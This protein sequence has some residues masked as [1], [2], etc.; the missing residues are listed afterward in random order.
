MRHTDIQTN[1][2]DNTCA[3]SEL[4]I[5]QLILQGNGS[6]TRDQ[7]QSTLVGCTAH[8]QRGRL[9]SNRSYQ[10]NQMNFQTK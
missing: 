10:V 8:A 7:F 9:L 6:K 1:Q 2:F 3:L 5:L 4:S